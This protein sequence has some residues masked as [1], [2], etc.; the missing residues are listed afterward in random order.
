MTHT[1]V[2]TLR[3]WI[4]VCESETQNL[5]NTDLSLPVHVPVKREILKVLQIWPILEALISFT[6]QLKHEVFN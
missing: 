6:T 1:I 3:V 2:V 5:E 4:L